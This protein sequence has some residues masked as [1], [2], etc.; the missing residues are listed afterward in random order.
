MNLQ[1]CLAAANSRNQSDAWYGESLWRHAREVFT[2]DAAVSRTIA[3]ALTLALLTAGCV[4]YSKDKAIE[5]MSEQEKAVLA[6]LSKITRNTTKAEV[7]ELLGK[8]DHSE[9]WDSW[10][11]YLNERTVNTTQTITSP[12]YRLSEVKNGQFT[13][14]SV[15]MPSSST[16]IQMKEKQWDSVVRVFFKNDRVKKIRFTHPGLDNGW[17]FELLK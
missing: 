15:Q 7:R 9:K 5:R 8:P 11:Y 1:T 17:S 2:L 13:G 6:E 12:S 14:G 16:T 3:L 4:T 10:E